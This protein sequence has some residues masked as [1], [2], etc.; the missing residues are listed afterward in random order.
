MSSNCVTYVQ[1]DLDIRNLITVK[2]NDATSISML[3]LL[4]SIHQNWSIRYNVT[5]LKK[6]IHDQLL[7][8]YV[9]SVMYIVFLD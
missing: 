7:L 3:S 9:I 8:S 2:V 4:N 1:M 6:F 5:T